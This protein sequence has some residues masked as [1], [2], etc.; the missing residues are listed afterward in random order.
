[1]SSNEKYDRQLRLWGPNGQ[2]CLAESHVLLINAT[3][4]GTETLKNL[5]LPGVGKFTVIDDEIVTQ[6]DT[7]GNFFVSVDQIGLPRAQAV[8]ELLCEM[9]PDVIGYFKVISPGTII[10]EDQDLVAVEDSYKTQS[11]ICFL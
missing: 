1:M 2:R 9:N 6:S 8:T 11:T 4:A 3:A 7:G 10:L 5:V